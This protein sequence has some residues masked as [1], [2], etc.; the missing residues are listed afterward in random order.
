MEG[1][2]EMTPAE[3]LGDIHMPNGSFYRSSLSLGL[4]IAAFGAMYQMF[5]GDDIW[6]IASY[7]CRWFNYYIRYQ[8]SSVQLLMIMDII[9]I[10]KT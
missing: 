10:K 3:P 4:F 7:Y 5:R 2:K 1:K 6:N 8:C 9:F